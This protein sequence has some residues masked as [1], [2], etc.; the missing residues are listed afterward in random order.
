MFGGRLRSF[1][2]SGCCLVVICGHL[3]GRQ[4]SFD[5]S[6]CCLVVICGNWGLVW[7]HLM[8]LVVVR[9]SALDFHAERSSNACASFCTGFPTFSP[10]HGYRSFSA[11]PSFLL[12]FP[13]TEGPARPL[14]LITMHAAGASACPNVSIRTSF[15]C[16]GTRRIKATILHQETE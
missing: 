6:G 7:G 15:T 5:G 11:C 8:D 12:S 9:W 1:D 13:V 16:E 2:G 4:G 10:L 3:G 14:L